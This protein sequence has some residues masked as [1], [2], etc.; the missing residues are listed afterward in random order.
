MGA[1]VLRGRKDRRKL[2]RNR[3]DLSAEQFAKMWNPLLGEGKIGQTL[4]PAWIPKESL[5]NL[6]ALARTG[7]DRHQLGHAR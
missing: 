1:G 7:T 5:R 2:L 3:W 4:L 6:L